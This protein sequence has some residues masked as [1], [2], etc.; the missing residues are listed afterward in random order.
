MPVETVSSNY[1]FVQRL[2][3]GGIIFTVGGFSVLGGER[4]MND[5]DTTGVPVDSTY[6]ADADFNVY[7]TGT[8]GLAKYDACI[9]KNPVTARQQ[10]AGSGLIL[11]LC[12]E[13]GRNPAGGSFDVTKVS[14]PGAASG[15]ILPGLDNVTGTGSYACMTSPPQGWG[16]GVH[17]SVKSL[18]NPTSSFTARLRGTYRDVFGQ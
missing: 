13:I 18:T 12:L 5:Y 9:I 1:T 10:A 14:G 7:C 11:T 6:V 2:I 4:L 15:I 3:L 16:S 17:L 8:G